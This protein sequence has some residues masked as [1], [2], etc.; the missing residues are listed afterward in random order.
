MLKRYT[1]VLQQLFIL[2][3]SLATLG[4]SSG[5][6]VEHELVIENDNVV[7]AGTLALPETQVADA[8]VIMLSGSGPQDRDETLEGFKVFKELSGQ[9][10]TDGIPSF[11]F[12]DRG[13]NGS[14]GNFGQ[15]TLHDHVLDVLEIINYFKNHQ[16]FPFKN[17]I[18]LG[19]SQGGIVAA[20]VATKSSDVKKLVLMA[21]PAVPL[22]DI[23]LY[24]VREEYFDKSLAPS[25]REAAVQAH[26]GLLWAINRNK[27]L[28]SPIAK[29]EEATRNALLAQSKDADSDKLQ[30]LVSQTSNE[31]KIIYALPSLTSFLYH[32]TARDIEQLKIPV[33]ALFGGK[34]Q[35][36]TIAQN[37]DVM[38]RALQ[39]SGS[40]FEFE[41]FDNANH[42][43]QA[44]VTGQR[45]EYSQLEKSFVP[46]F[47]EN[48]S[49]WILQ[50]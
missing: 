27:D 12:D 8:L 11:R 49:S 46:E 26:N 22:I 40:Q 41:T 14:T 38:E 3:V 43:F 42:F 24:Q 29:F 17:F 44:A 30:E 25:L 16:R 48:I 15:S 2:M 45:A 19:H 5:Q 35:Q 7:I 9:L 23:L 34:D 28:S 31:H 18:L 33:L 37:K 1:F 6:A 20:N 21:S 32:D 10:Q 4:V 36:V 47:A 13:V 39:R 50:Q